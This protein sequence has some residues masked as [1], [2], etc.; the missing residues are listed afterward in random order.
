MDER[1]TSRHMVKVFD[2][3]RNPGI[4]EM[5]KEEQAKDPKVTSIVTVGRWGMVETPKGAYFL[6][7]DGVGQAGP[8]DRLTVEFHRRMG[9][10][11]GSNQFSFEPFPFASAT[12]TLDECKACLTGEELTL[13]KF[14]GLG[15]RKDD[16]YATWAKALD[17]AT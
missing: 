12:F 8:S 10:T 3:N 6:T 1:Q 7:D 17:Q 9:E 5:L 2:L 16:N 13:D 14:I 4:D 11:N 15:R